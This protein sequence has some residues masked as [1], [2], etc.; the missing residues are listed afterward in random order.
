MASSC[1]AT[2]HH[3]FPL[4]L[5]TLPLLEARLDP[6]QRTEPLQHHLVFSRQSRCQR[7]QAASWVVVLPKTPCLKIGTSKTFNQT[8]DGAFDLKLFRRDVTWVSLERDV[9]ALQRPADLSLQG[10][11]TQDHDLSNCHQPRHGF[12]YRPC[13]IAWAR[14]TLTLQGWWAWAQ[15]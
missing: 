4:W 2:Y 9:P 12:F 10:L 7:T 15:R 1:S 6:M 11:I 3:I 13:I 8:P 14:L 5:S